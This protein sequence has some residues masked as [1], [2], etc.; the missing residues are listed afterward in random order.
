MHVIPSF[1]LEDQYL[2]IMLPSNS[3]VTHVFLVLAVPEGEGE[4]T[5]LEVYNFTG[6]GG[7]T[8]AMYN[9]DEVGIQFPLLI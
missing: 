8:L 1:F 3:I 7:V 5:E 2:F 9:T 4:K 6:E